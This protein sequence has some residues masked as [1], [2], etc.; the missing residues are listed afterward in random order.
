MSTIAS[1]IPLSVQNC[2]EI[3]NQGTCIFVKALD[4]CAKEPTAITIT[5]DTTPV[6]VDDETVSLTASVADTFL[7][8][9][10]ILTFGANTLT[11]L[12]DVTVGTT[13]TSVAIEPATAI[14]A[15]AATAE[16]FA[17]LELLSPENVPYNI[18]ATTVDRTD[19]KS[20]QTSSVKTNNGFKPQIQCIASKDD[21]ALWQVFEGAR[22]VRD[23]YAVIYYSS[24]QLVF[25]RAIITGYNFD[26]AKSEIQR[27]QFT[28]EFQGDDYRTTTTYLEADANE[29]AVMNEIARLAGIPE[30]A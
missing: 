5:V 15:A 12:N 23:V 7:R 22:T 29:Q 17:L 2:N 11:V 19:L 10:T 3:L 8:A 18:E 13:A 30:F 24:D 4:N 20:F 25:G 21:K 1:K 26:G 6:A 27:P 9:G 16:T 28:L 14:I